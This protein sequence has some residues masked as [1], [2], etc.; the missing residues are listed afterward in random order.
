MSTQSQSLFDSLKG[1]LS[2][3]GSNRSTKSNMSSKSNR[4]SH[5]P[6]PNPS[7]DRAAAP[8]TAPTSATASIPTS[9][10][11]SSQAPPPSYSE[12]ISTSATN[13]T[14]TVQT[15]AANRAPSPAPSGAS[16]IS[17]ASASTPDD[18]FA[19]LSTFDT[20]FLIDDSGSMAGRSWREVKEALRAI[21]P[22]C[23]AH[24]EDGIDVYFI[25]AKNRHE[26]GGG[27]KN[28]RSAAQVEDLFNTVRPG[29]GTP[30][31]ARLNNITKLYMAEYEEAV[32]RAGGEADE[33]DVKPMNI[34]VITDGVPTDDPETVI[35][36]L[37]K[38]LDKLNAPLY[39]VG[40]QFFQVGN[41]RG[42]AEALKD[43]DD[44]LSGKRGGV[45]DMVDTVTWSGRQGRE[46]ALTADGILKVVLGAV[47]RRLDRRRASGESSRPY[48]AP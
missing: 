42:A 31:G 21:T 45:R 40:I 19:F 39:Q 43:L 17:V 29:G 46:R 15:P 6:N 30:I 10:S 26:E 2:R 20:I 9:T 27:W 47:V 35:T 34:I 24:D 5:N 41:E 16:R 13:P 1:K 12:A 38:K 22:I 28:I 8:A 3:K 44:G 14:I 36:L 37:A 25:N 23:T 18:P 32:R 33:T 11:T 7:S 4:S 48:L